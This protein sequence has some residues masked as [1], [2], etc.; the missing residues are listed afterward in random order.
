MGIGAAWRGLGVELAEQV[1]G[2]DWKGAEP[3]RAQEEQ[4]GVRKGV[5]GE[6]GPVFKGG[7][8]WVHGRGRPLPAFP[9]LRALWSGEWRSRDGVCTEGG[10]LAVAGLISGGEHSIL[11]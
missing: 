4:H 3:L 2:G 10:S 9:A 11:R 7:L 1:L 8:G 6:V 5:K